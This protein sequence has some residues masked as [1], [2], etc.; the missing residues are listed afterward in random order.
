[1]APNAEEFDLPLRWDSPKEEHYS[2]T[3]LAAAYTIMLRSQR[4]VPAILSHSGKSRS[5]TTT[6]TTLTRCHCIKPCN[7]RPRGQ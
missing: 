7:M 6:T 1:V 5:T 2:A 4:K 3:I